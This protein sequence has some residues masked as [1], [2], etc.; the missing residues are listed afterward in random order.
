[1]T[2]MGRIA[3]PE[4]Q[5][6]LAAEIFTEAIADNKTVTA[7]KPRPDLC[8]FFQGVN[9]CPGGSDGGQSALLEHFRPRKV[10]VPDLVPRKR[11]PRG[12]E[13]YR[14]RPRK[15]TADQ[16]KA[17]QQRPYQTLREL[18]AEYGVSHETIRAARQTSPPD[19]K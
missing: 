3:I 12:T 11:T 16:F 18:A 17:I 6:M 8:P 4:N 2:E 9:W 7:V 19:A 13:R 10:P 1:M 14:C 15:L 5:Y